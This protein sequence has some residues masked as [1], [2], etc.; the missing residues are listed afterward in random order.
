MT[1]TVQTNDGKVTI[2]LEGRLDTA[3]SAKTSANINTLLDTLGPPDISLQ[4][5]TA[6][7]ALAGKAV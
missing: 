5:R 1:T 7:P 2:C 4:L 3:T 6:H